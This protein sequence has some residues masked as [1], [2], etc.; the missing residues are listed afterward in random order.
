MN[1]QIQMPPINMPSCHMFTQKPANPT[2]GDIYVDNNNNVYI[3]SNTSWQLLTIQTDDQVD[4]TY[5]YRRMH[6]KKRT[7]I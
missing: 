2:N 4:V 6:E 3:Y 5:S 7:Y 1:I